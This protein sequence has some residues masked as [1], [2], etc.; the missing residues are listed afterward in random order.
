LWEPNVASTYVNDVETIM[1]SGTIIT[2]NIYHLKDPESGEI[3]NTVHDFTLYCPCP[4]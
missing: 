1:S 2:Q 4:F 3:F